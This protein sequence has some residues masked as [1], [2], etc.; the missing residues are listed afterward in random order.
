MISYFILFLFILFYILFYFNLFYH[1]LFNFILFYIFILFLSLR[2]RPPL[3][4]VAVG[5]PPLTAHPQRAQG[6]TQLAAA[7]SR[8]VEPCNNFLPAR[9]GCL[10]GSDAATDARDGAAG[11]EATVGP[12]DWVR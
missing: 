9:G 6:R 11:A 10:C 12:G 2:Q 3:S 8:P 1:I 4:K 5:A 7:A